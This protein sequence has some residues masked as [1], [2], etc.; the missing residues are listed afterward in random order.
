M[1][2]NIF[3]PEKIGSVYIFPQRTVGFDIG[4]TQ[5]TATQVMLKGKQIIIEKIMQ[6]KLEPAANGN[7]VDRVA[8]AISLIVPKLD[9]Y[10]QMRTSLTSTAVLFKEISLPFLQADKIEAILPLEIEPLLP[11]ALEQADFDFIITHQSVPEKKSTVLIAATQKETIAAHRAAFELAGISPQVIMVDIIALFGLYKAIPEYAQAMDDTVLIDLGY[12]VTRIAF[13]GQGQLRY[14]RTL[15]KGVS[16]MTELLSEI[17]FTLAAFASQ[18]QTTKAPRLILIGGGAQVVG[19]A[20]FIHQTIGY[21]AE[22]FAI[23]QLKSIPGLTISTK[24]QIPDNAV[25]S[26]ATAIP[27]PPAADFNLDKHFVAQQEKSSLFKQLIVAALMCMTILVAVISHSFLQKR[28]LRQNIQQAQQEAVDVLGK[29]FKITDSKILS[30]LQDTL[31]TAAGSL[32]KDEAIWYAFSASTRLSFLK[33]LQELST[34]INRDRIGLI[35]K[36]LLMTE[37]LIVLDGQVKDFDSL[38]ILEQSL[39]SSQLFTKIS[40]PDDT[41]FSLQITLKKDGATRI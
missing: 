35:L 20:D 28:K 9:P 30:S 6:E 10:G 34:I 14:V 5:V 8:K 36:R 29:K 15:P 16:Q 38:A 41:K 11:F 7:Y 26:I 3:I 21:Q 22:L 39:R 4:K 31:E 33:Y 23:N 40:K 18:A 1:I 2:K 12:Q 13:I 32:N 25:I 27:L 37:D 24:G 19:F 17:Q